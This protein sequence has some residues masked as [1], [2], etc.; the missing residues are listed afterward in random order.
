MRCRK[1]SNS[2][3]RF[4]I[5]IPSGPIKWANH[6]GLMH[7]VFIMIGFSLQNVDLLTNPVSWIYHMRH[8]SFSHTSYVFIRCA[9]C[10]QY[11]LYHHES[12]ATYQW[13]MTPQ[14]NISN[15]KLHPP[16]HNKNLSRSIYQEKSLILC[17][18]CGSLLQKSF[19]YLWLQILVYLILSGQ[20]QVSC[21]TWL[22]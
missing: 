7:W 11:C 18:Q 14:M 15:I 12:C 8:I 16:C 1:A 20:S 17:K 10:L 22:G 3:T 5:G 13:F 21:R 19:Y 2:C 9:S 4:S 6:M